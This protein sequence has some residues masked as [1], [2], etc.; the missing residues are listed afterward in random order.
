[1]P[2]IKTTATHKKT[3]RVFAKIFKKNIIEM[4]ISDRIIYP[5]KGYIL[6]EKDFVSIDE[7]LEKKKTYED[8][9]EDYLGYPIYKFRYKRGIKIKNNDLIEAD[10]R[11][12]EAQFEECAAE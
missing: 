1:M 2:R 5:P 6:A 11:N 4:I 3:Y 9:K 7:Y 8:Y 10:K 12:I